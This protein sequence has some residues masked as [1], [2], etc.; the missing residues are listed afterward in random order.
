[1][2]PGICVIIERSLA[3]KMFSNNLWTSGAFTLVE[4]NRTVV[5][6]DTGSFPVY[7]WVRA[8]PS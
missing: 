1:M 8:R 2:A 4:L 5:F 6:N 3:S 7:V